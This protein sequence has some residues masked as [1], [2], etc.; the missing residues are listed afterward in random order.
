MG[1]VGRRNDHLAFLDGKGGWV[2]SL[3]GVYGE[4]SGRFLGAVVTV[5]QVAPESI[6]R[7]CGSGIDRPPNAQQKSE[8]PSSCLLLLFYTC[9]PEDKIKDSFKGP[10]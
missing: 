10:P 5:Q 7:C 4:L 1:P 8:P 6:G 9:W 3:P 2:P